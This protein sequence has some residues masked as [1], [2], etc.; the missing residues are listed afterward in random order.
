MAK[1]SEFF[2]DLEELK[3]D[4]EELKKD[5]KEFEAMEKEYQKETSFNKKW[6]YFYK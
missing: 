4:I 1:D 5:M 6:D 3:A 2:S